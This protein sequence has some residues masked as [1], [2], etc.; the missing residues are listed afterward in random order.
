MGK[1]R[2]F[3]VVM[4]A[5]LSLSAG[6]QSWSRVGGRKQK[7]LQDTVLIAYTDSLRMLSARCFAD[8]SLTF[9]A[10]G[11][12]LEEYEEQVA[13]LFLPLTF[14]RGVTEQ[15][16]ARPADATQESE[17]RNSSSL[18]VP[19]TLAEIYLQRPDLVEYTQTGLS[20]KG[21]PD[22]VEPSKPIHHEVELVDMVAPTTIDPAVVPVDVVITKPNFWQIK[23]DYSL[24]L[25]QNYTSGNWYKG[26]ESN[27][28][29]IAAA[30]IEANYNNR[31]KVKW[32]NK[33]ELKY[34]LQNYRSDSLHHFK[35]TEDLIR[36]T[37]KFGLQST[38]HWYYT[39][40]VI[41]NTQFSNSYKAN[42]PV[43]YSAFMA[44]FNLNISLGMDYNVDWL[45]HKL[46]GSFHLAPLAY[47]LKYT[48]LE[49]LA[50]KLGVDEGRKALN[51][52][53]YECTADLTWQ[54]AEMISWKT[55]LYVYSSYKRM[56]LEWENTFKLQFNRW[57]SAQLFVFP[58]F[59]DG[60]TRDGHHGYWQLKEYA[61]I[62]FNYNF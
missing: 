47:N 36:L 10:A 43:V 25:M 61:S 8:S 30:T 1:E 51:D 48:R 16:F 44:P 40:Q 38:K 54:L 55:R 18:F 62:G 52:F 29:A 2:L 34:G 32:E 35:T 56:E 3:V 24:Q 22:D 58:R 11:D 31:Q 7:A 5:L 14:Y 46:K 37:S 59:D 27:Y 50:T 21:N 17:L 12:T 57:I 15:L 4:L 42:D 33:L 20:S 28:S 41:A 26:G 53:G 13:S 6:A 60:G 39:F 9:S 23:N 19:S 49:E 45:K